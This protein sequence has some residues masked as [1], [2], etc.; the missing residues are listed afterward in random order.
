MGKCQIS[1]NLGT[2]TGVNIL[3][4]VL[5]TYGVTLDKMDIMVTPANLYAARF[6]AFV[7]EVTSTSVVRLKGGF[8]R[9]DVSG[10]PPVASVATDIPAEQ[11]ALYNVIAI[12][13]Y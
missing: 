6:P 2:K 7:D 1:I 5:D 3:F 12:K 13:R 9:Y 11:E 10:A 8:T 4:P